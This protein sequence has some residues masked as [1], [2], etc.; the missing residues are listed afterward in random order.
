MS[1]TSIIN[2][3]EAKVKGLEQAIAQSVQNHTGLLGMLQGT[4]EA[5]VDAM[6]VVDFVAPTSGVAE[7]LNVADNVVTDLEALVPAG[8]EP[9][10]EPIVG[11]E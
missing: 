5:L 6:K 4:K 10:V 9:V 8:A 3:L 1:V 7:A 2:A 11:A